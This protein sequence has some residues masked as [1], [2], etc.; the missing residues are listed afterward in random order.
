MLSVQKQFGASRTDEVSAP[1]DETSFA[2]VSLPTHTIA[3]DDRHASL[4]GLHDAAIGAGAPPLC[5]R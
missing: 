3:F 4:L 2:L 5:L 1:Y